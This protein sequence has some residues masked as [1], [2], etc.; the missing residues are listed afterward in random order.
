[1]LLL[2]RLAPVLL[3]VGYAL[4]L[5]YASSRRLLGDLERTSV[6]LAEPGLSG[7]LDRL[8]QAL[9]RERIAVWMIRNPAVNG[10]AA[11]DGR[12]YLT[13]GLVRLYRDGKVSAAELMSVVAHELGHVAHGHARRRM[14]DYSGQTAMRS[15]LASLFGRLLPIRGAGAWLANLA[16]AAVAARM[17]RSAEFEAD[18]FASALLLKA[19]IGLAPQIALFEK[20]DQIAGGRD[21]PPPAWF[22]SHPKSPDRIARIRANAARWGEA[23]A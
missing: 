17:S 7:G 10:L 13:E 11:P 14:I 20:L 9:G 1:M 3:A 6:P 22:A 18:E 2:M 5:W 16:S 21:T 12:V 19:G 4:L 8:A 23:T 15:L